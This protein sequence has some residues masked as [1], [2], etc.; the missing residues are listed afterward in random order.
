MFWQHD[1][2]HDHH[3]LESCATVA[4]SEDIGQYPAGTLLCD[5]LND[6]DRRLKQAQVDRTHGFVPVAFDAVIV[7]Y[8]GAATAN[9]LVPFNA[10]LAAAGSATFALDA[11]LAAPVTVERT[12]AFGMGAY[13][14]ERAAVNAVTVLTQPVG[15]G[16]TTIHIDDPGEFGTCPMTI[17]IGLETMTVIA[18]C[19]TTTWTVIR[20][21]PAASHPVGAY[22][23]DC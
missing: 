13:L 23:V 1:R 4:L 12:G 8:A 15:P 10:V 17:Q 22:V 5:V 16:D 2:E 6:M 20:G 3:G 9:G 7:P 19:E 18:G 21:D 11:E 14:L